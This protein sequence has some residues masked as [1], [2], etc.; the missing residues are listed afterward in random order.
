MKNDETTKWQVGSLGLNS[1]LRSTLISSISL[2]Q[3]IW[4]PADVPS[5]QSDY[6]DKVRSSHTLLHALQKVAKEKNF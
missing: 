4:I 5:R 6:R 2:E 3:G 1:S